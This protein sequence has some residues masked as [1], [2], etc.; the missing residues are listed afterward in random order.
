[1]EVEHKYG[2]TTIRK[3]PERVVTVGLTDQDTV[4]ALGTA[5]VGVR[6]WFGDQP[7]A[8]WP[9]ARK[10]L[11]ERPVPE[12]LPRQELEFERI[13]ALRPDV[14]IGINS[15]LGKKE[16]DTLARI[17]P[18]VAQPAEHADYG[19]PW[20]QLTRKLGRILGRGTR[21]EKLV[22]DIESRLRRA[23][24]QHPEFEGATGMLATSISGAAYAYAT[25]PAPRLLRTLGFKM[26]D[27]AAKLFTGDDQAPVELSNERLGVLESDVL[28]VGVYG[29]GDD[30]VTKLPIYRRLDVA[31]QGRDIEMP[32][33]SALNGS[34]SFSSP[35]SL[36]IALAELVPRLASA[37][38][39]DP[40]TKVA[41]V[42]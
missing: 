13:A 17:A 18:T 16:Y 37:I 24:S 12:V 3:R 6:E 35:L 27:A 42:E 20:Q 28:L 2:T 19:V 31:R 4:L 5:P 22:E 39:G 8:L 41:P 30:S 1:M 34:V 15:G 25:G 36:P 23:R 33:T 29:S 7:G 40:G 11:G 21:A 14:I 9:W 10:T 38:D 26:P 32:K